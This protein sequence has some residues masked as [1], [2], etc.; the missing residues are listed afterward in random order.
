MCCISSSPNDTSLLI[1]FSLSLCPPP[2]SPHTHTLSHLISLNY[3]GLLFPNC[4]FFFLSGTQQLVASVVPVSA[5]MAKL[6]S[7][8]VNILYML[9]E[10]P[11]RWVD[12]DE[13]PP[14]P[15]TATTTTTAT[16]AASAT[17]TTV[18]V[19]P[20]TVAPTAA[21]VSVVVVESS[22]SSAPDTHLVIGND[23]TPVAVEAAGA[24]DVEVTATEAV[25]EKVAVAEVSSSSSSSSSSQGEQGDGGGEGDVDSAV[26]MK[27][28]EEREDN[29]ES[30]VKEITV[31]PTESVQVPP[32][33]Q[34]PVP[35]PTVVVVA[36]TAKETK[37]ER[38]LKRRLKRRQNNER[39]MSLIQNA[40]TP[41][42]LLDVLVEVEEAIPKIYKY[43]LNDEAL[44]S[45]A[46][47][48]A[49]LAVRIYVLDRRIRYDEIKEVEKQGMDRQYRPR[50]QFSPRCLIS[51]SCS[52]FLSHAGKCA[53]DTPLT[54][55]TTGSRIPDI[56][57]ALTTPNYSN[58]NSQYAQRASVGQPYTIQNRYV[59]LIKFLMTLLHFLCL[60]NVKYIDH[61]NAVYCIELYLSNYI[62][63]NYIT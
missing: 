57:D 43:T 31:T 8:L 53:H 42:Q 58:I 34:I 59:L 10:K 29:L 37:V 38:K 60:F 26:I 25:D 5:R 30:K 12:K 63:Y 19:P 54:T 7:E 28:D 22:S 45:T 61:Y 44:P 27:T 15:P 2:P 62:T 49:A 32:P 17:D 56:H 24:M 3:T 36:E 13:T 41:Q 39:I 33:D 1:L 6:K 23:D 46:D 51:S 35:V 47:T 11:M 20:V 50:Y 52:K 21:A 40:R 18:G 9:P 55:H 4:A 48:C 16:T 14:V